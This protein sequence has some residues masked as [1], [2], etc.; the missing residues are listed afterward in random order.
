METGGTETFGTVL[1]LAKSVVGNVIDVPYFA[2][3]MLAWQPKNELERWNFSATKIA[4]GG[5]F[6][7][8]HDK[9]LVDHLEE[10]P[11]ILSKYLG[12]SSIFFYMGDGDTKLHVQYSASQAKLRS[13]F[14]Y[15]QTQVIRLGEPTTK[16]EGATSCSTN[17][18]HSIQVVSHIGFN[19]RV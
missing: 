4:L 7:S 14:I 8:I 1:K 6:C 10:V 13:V 19:R 9:I 12:N 16:S 5:E 17:N 11:E 15:R 18:E 2:K 3:C